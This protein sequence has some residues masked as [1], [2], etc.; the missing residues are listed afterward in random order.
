VSVS[1]VID[2]G[3]NIIGADSD[4]DDRSDIMQRR[5]KLVAQ[6]NNVICS[7]V[8]LDPVIKIKLLKSC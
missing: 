4:K 2:D 7:L 6:I 3:D 1:T 8:N 5:V